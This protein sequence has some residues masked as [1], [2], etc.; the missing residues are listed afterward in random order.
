MEQSELGSAFT[1][2]VLQIFRVNGLVLAE[3]EL[4]TADLGLTSARWQVMGTLENG[5]LPVP[6]I[7]REMGL[8]RQGVQKTVKILEHD[9]LI[10][11][12]ENPHH[13]TAKLV[14]LSPEG[15]KRLDLLNDIQVDWATE[16]AA[17]HRLEDLKTAVRVIRKVVISLEGKQP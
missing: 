15:R 1:A 2:L 3:G 4:L 5:G 12:Q 11:L 13:K 8:T 6:H 16:I 17:S 7:A 14:V 9:G 10:E